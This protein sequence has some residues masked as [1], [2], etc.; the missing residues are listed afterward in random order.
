MV[1]P[2]RNALIFWTLMHDITGPVGVIMHPHRHFIEAHLLDFYPFYSVF[3]HHTKQRVIAARHNLS[4]FFRPVPTHHVLRWP[5]QLKSHTDTYKLVPQLLSHI[6][7]IPGST[8]H[9]GFTVNVLA[10]LPPLWIYTS[11]RLRKH[12]LV[13]RILIQVTKNHTKVPTSKPDNPLTNRHIT[14]N[15]DWEVFLI[16]WIS[17]KISDGLEWTNTLLTYITAYLKGKSIV[18][19]TLNHIIFLENVQQFS[20]HYSVALSDDIEKSFDRITAKTWI[21]AMYQHEYP[22]HGYVEWIAET[23]HHSNTTFTTKHAHITLPN[24]CGAKQR[25]SFVCIS[26][27]CVA[28]LKSRAFFVPPTFDHN[29][30]CMGI[31]SNSIPSTND[32]AC[33]ILSLT[34]NPIVI[35]I[36]DTWYT[37]AI[38]L[39]DLILQVWWLLDMAGGFSFITKLGRKH[40]KC[41]VDILNHPRNMWRHRSTSP[42]GATIIRVHTPVP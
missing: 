12:C 24:L 29:T 11:P 35:T 32:T 39:P 33:I 13:H 16:E 20:S 30:Y 36:H 18:D 6:R 19:L 9:D 2:P 25:S 34:Y 14:L 5:W 15:H 38:I 28:S 8:R 3:D 22:R 41:S 4:H 1:P 40:K 26:S 31:Y 23:S 37:V 10:R 42:R 21:V 7:G 27:I 17:N